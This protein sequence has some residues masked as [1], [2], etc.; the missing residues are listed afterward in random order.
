MKQ[1]EGSVRGGNL[2]EAEQYLTKSIKERSRTGSSDRRSGKNVR[3]MSER[4]T[5]DALA[6]GTLDPAAA[7]PPGRFHLARRIWSRLD[8]R[9]S[10]RRWR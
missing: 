4:A 9:A 5:F 7:P 8:H 6:A 2:G 1:R 10:G 3:M